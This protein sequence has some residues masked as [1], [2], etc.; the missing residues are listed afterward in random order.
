MP[1]IEVTDQGW[2]ITPPAGKALVLNG[3]QFRKISQTV[4][5]S[6]FTDG[7]GAVGTKDLSE[8][9]PAGAIY[10][11]TAVTA[12][13]GFAGDT[14]ALMTIG[15]GTDVDR[16]NAGTI[17]VFATAAGGVAAGVPSGALYHAAQV[18]PKLTITS[19][20]DFTNVSAGSV[21]VELYY[22]T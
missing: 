11:G 19:A 15:D 1:D 21:S 12:V 10:M 5:R 13:T 2:S 3:M 9:I 20:A 16:Y 4:P 18:T 6:E 7:G 22:Y 14:S 8:V 17:N